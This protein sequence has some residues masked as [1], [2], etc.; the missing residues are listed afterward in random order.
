MKLGMVTYELGK[1]MDLKTLLAT[2]RETGFK[3]VELRTTHAHGVE[4][5]MPEA[6]WAETKTMFADSGV[7]LWGL[8][9]VCEYHAVDQAVVRRN[10]EQ[11]KQWIE[12]AAHVGARGVKVRPNGMPKEVEQEK[13]CQQI[14]SALAE[15]GKAAADAGVLIYLEVHGAVSSNPKLCQK[16]MEACD[17]PSVGVCWNSNNNPDEVI[18][19]SIATTFPLL[20]KWI[21]SCHITE[22]S[23][24]YPWR[25]L[26]RLLKES[27]YE[28]ATLA[29]IPASA[30]PARLMRY[31]R[32]LWE[33]YQA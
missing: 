27:G 11:T 6:K 13:T 29:E 12:L 7:E 22:L 3:A 33:A 14:G 1:A 17:H 10:I 19:G 15:C 2:C 24:N 25:E 32:A 31:Y 8:G 18:N 4:L 30:E 26:F 23:S 28:G 9:T 21:K 16:M 5:G 20:S